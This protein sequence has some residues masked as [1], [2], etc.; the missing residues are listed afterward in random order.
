M[1]YNT[2][3]APSGELRITLM[4]ARPPSCHTAKETE[5]RKLVPQHRQRPHILVFFPPQRAC[6]DIAIML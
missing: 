1:L 5:A 4:S 2:G 6:P 3:N